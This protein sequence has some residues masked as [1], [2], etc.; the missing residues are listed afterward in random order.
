MRTK[1]IVIATAATAALGAAAA[2]TFY[3]MNFNL[4]PPAVPPAQVSVTVQPAPF[5]TPAMEEERRQAIKSF[6]DEIAHLK[7]EGLLK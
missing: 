4:M 6:D 5:P 2:G 1:T 3:V 7:A